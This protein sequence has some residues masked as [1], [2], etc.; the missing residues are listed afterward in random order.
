MMATATPEYQR[1]L[2]TLTGTGLRA[3]EF[4]ELRLGDVKN[5][6]IHIRWQTSK[7]GRERFVPL[8]PEVAE[9]IKKQAKAMKRTPFERLWQ[10]TDWALLKTIKKIAKRAGVEEWESLRTHDLRRTFGTRCA[11]AGMPLPQLS[12]IMGHSNTQVTSQFYV[13]L[14]KRDNAA[15]MALVAD[16]LLVD[17]NGVPAK[18]ASA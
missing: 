9:A 2:T 1:G 8:V 4:L 10:Q 6:E 14:N 3:N 15:A 17:P 5:G 18:S 11:R 7:G 16:R 13:H 12:A